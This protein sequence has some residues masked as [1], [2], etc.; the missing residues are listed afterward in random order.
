MEAIALTPKSAK[1]KTLLKK[2]AGIP[3]KKTPVPKFVK[4]AQKGGSNDI[5][6]KKTPVSK[7]VKGSQK[8]DSIDIPLKKTPVPKF[9]KGSQKDDSVDIPLKK[10]PVLKALS[11]KVATTEF[12]KILNKLRSKADKAPTME[13]ITAEVEMIR[14]KRYATK[15]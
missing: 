3:L 5:P 4:G 1:P 2:P 6:L 7:I 10:T 14:N 12:R 9:V 13:D 8:T 11:T 15:R